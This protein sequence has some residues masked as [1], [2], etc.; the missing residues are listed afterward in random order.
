MAKTVIALYDDV[1]TAR[2]V[3]QDLVDNGFPRDNV[4]IMASDAAGEYDRYQSGEYREDDG[5]GGGA[6]AGAGIGAVIG[7]I[8][9][10]LVGLG[11][12]TIPGVGPVIAA[13]PLAAALAGAGIGAVAGGLIGALTDMG[14][15]EDEAGY[16][17][18]GVRR[19]GTLVAVRADN[20]RADDAASI[21]SRYNPV[22]IEERAS[23]WR[24]RGWSGYDPNAEPYDTTRIE[25]ERGYLGTAG[26][27]TTTTGT[28]RDRTHERTERTSGE[29]SIP[30]IEE[31]VAVGKRQ[32]Q[33]G[34]VRVHT[35]VREVPVEETVRLRDEEINV[36]RRPA[37]RRAE[38]GEFDTLQE[39]T[40]EI[41]E[42]DEEAVV[43]KDA[44]VVEEVVVSKDVRER[45]E[46]VRD[47]ARRTDVEVEQVGTGRTGTQTGTSTGFETYESDYRNHFQ[48]NYGQG[49]RS[50]NDYQPA[51]RY[52]HTLATDERYRGRDWNEVE[53]EAR[54]HWETEHRDQGAWEDFKDS[55]RHAWNRARTA[56]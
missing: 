16:Y 13:G 9:G 43:S 27:T 48:S 51:Y 36:E 31:D 40:I 18:E 20:A 7:G 21:M 47:T 11:A 4:S 14:V 17:A 34:G 15:P 33:R 49:G 8:G 19:G 12:L 5:V 39:G 50:Y 6:A 41:T 29:Q 46:T 42:T 37:D 3:V 53:P 2:D 38:R 32:V 45:E 25:E 26:R 22:D 56:V 44:R 35:H 24:E 23:S 10:L 28:E 30:V 54:R 52:G 1:H 55:V